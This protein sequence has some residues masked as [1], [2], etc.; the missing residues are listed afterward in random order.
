MADQRFRAQ[1]R[2]PGLS[3]ASTSG[4]KGRFSPRGEDPLAELARLIGQ[5]DPF[6]GFSDNPRG[7]Q[8]P[9][10]NGYAPRNGRDRH[11]GQDQDYDERDAYDREPQ[12]PAR[13]RRYAE[14]DLRQPD[15]NAPRKNGRGAYAYGGGRD[16]ASHWR[17]P[18]E[19]AASREP[20]ASRAL[21]PQPAKRP[22]R[23]P[24]YAQE[25]DSDDP[26]YARTA[27]GENGYAD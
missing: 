15:M 26:R 17:L 18:P 23:Q 4:A 20:N 19:P 14:E 22:A 5:D 7:A 1:Q 3:Q 25:A 2:D 24:D 27:R 9:S 13:A 11:S 16:E 8:Q 10:G 6:S 21:P 12:A